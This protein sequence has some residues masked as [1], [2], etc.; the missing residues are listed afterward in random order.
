MKIELRTA[1]TPKWLVSN[2]DLI[3]EHRAPTSVGPNSSSTSSSSSKSSI[4]SSRPGK[5]LNA[6]KVGASKRQSNKATR[7]KHRSIAAR[8]GGASGLKAQS[9]TVLIDR[10]KVLKTGLT[11]TRLLQRLSRSLIS[12]LEPEPYKAY[13][14]L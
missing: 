2:M 7:S 5:L 6:V 10:L 12:L 4:N 9:I 3:N 8:L 14:S 11:R 13:K 1:R